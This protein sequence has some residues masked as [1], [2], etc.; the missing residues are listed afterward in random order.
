MDGVMTMNFSGGTAAI[1]D[2]DMVTAVALV[3]SGVGGNAAF[4]EFSRRQ[5]TVNESVFFEAVKNAI[6]RDGLCFLTFLGHEV[7]HIVGGYRM[8][9]VVEY[10]QYLLSWCGDTEPIGTEG[11]NRVGNVGEH[12][13]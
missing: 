11:F 7:H 3:M 12:K 4:D 13:G 10:L 9:R 5:N 8:H 1:T 6:D 2:G